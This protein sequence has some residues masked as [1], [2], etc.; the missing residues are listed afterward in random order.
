MRPVSGSSTFDSVTAFSMARGPHLDAVVLGGYQVAENGVLANWKVP[1][2]KPGGMGGAMDL[3]A[4]GAPVIVVMEHTTVRGEP[5]LVSRC[6][7]PLTGLGCVTTVVT[8][9]ALIDVTSEGFA[10]RELAPGVSVEAVRAA[11][12]CAIAIPD[13][14]PPMRFE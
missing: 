11:T 5:R 9:L 8:N 13:D 1:G 12:A 7:Y 3:V 4:G 14:P 2:P 10:L 6:D